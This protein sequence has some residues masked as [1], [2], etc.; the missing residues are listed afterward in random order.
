MIEVILTII[1]GIIIGVLFAFFYFRAKVESLARKRGD[2]LGQRVFEQRKAE[3][4]GVFDEKFKALL[5]R[6]KIESEKAFREDALARSRAVLKGALA[7]QLA[8]IFKIFG[9][10]PS[11]ARFIGDPVDYVIFDGYTKVKERIEDIPIT[12][13]LADVKTGEA[14][15]TY[16]QR[17]IQRGIENGRVKFETIRM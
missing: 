6:W 8:P 5:E 15:L 11:D 10:N 3:L 2:E 12:I 9:Y 1:V 14:G 13:V 4:E 7:E 16:E 17:R